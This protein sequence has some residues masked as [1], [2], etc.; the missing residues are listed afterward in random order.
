MKDSWKKSM[1]I[2]KTTL[3]ECVDAAGSINSPSNGLPGGPGTVVPGIYVP[4]EICVGTFTLTEQECAVSTNN[5][6]ESLA[7]ENLNVSGAPVNVFKLLG[8]HEQG[9][10]I[11]LTGNGVAIGSGNP[12]NAFDE[13]IDDWTSSEEGINVAGKAYVGYDFGIRKTT[14]GQPE[15][16]KGA[17][18]NQHI[19][20]FRITQGELQENRALQV[21][22]ERSLGKF[23]IDPLKIK[24]TGAGNGG[25]GGFQEGVQPQD[26]YFMLFAESSSQFTV[27]FTSPKGTQILGMADV[28]KKFNSLIGSFTIHAGSIPFE[29]G[30]SFTVPVQMDWLRVDVINL[31]NIPTPVMVRIKQ[32]APSR[33]WRLVPTSFAGASTNQPWVVKKLELFDHQATRLDDIQDPLLMENR[34]R[35]YA[36]SSIQLKASYTPF[37]AMM[38]LSKFGF[39]MADIYTFNVSFAL[40]ITLLGRP[41]VVGDILE[42]PAEMQYD[43]NLRPVRRFLEVS[44]VGW[45]ADGFTTG[46]KPIIYRFQAQQL[47]PSQEHRD[48]LGT[49][50]TQKYIIDDGT[51]MAGLEQIQTVPLT[52]T[53]AN[54]QDALDDAPE[55]G[56]NVR[57]YASGT[58]RFKRPGSYDGV[59]L[60]VEDGLPPDGQPYTTGFNKL[61][62]VAE[63]KD[64]EFFRLEYPPALNM[65][66]RLYKFSGVKNKWIYVETD[67]RSS[68]SSHKP[69]QRAIFDMEN[70]MSPKDQIK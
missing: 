11:D 15:T 39:Q 68:R 61:P 45:A 58:N 13:L 44:D 50:D 29:A 8:I 4:P 19:T 3:D 51:F 41:I 49:V 35:D 63:S 28:N 69:S 25:V 60:Y 21:R 31:P 64:G 1:A 30:D 67:R 32:S 66:A 17:P 52:V 7:A 18:D 23:S 55:K 14:Y 57:E 36:K 40:M 47:I 70:K 24:F 22:V 37:D 43:H 16:G 48:L 54:Y 27:A 46:W 59:G 9:K 6:Q 65:P 10:L 42:L 34:D 12:K 38:D 56:T 53:E 26:G 33:Y 20:S 2:N 62:D 5:Y